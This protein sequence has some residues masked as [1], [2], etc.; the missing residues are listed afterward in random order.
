MT[1]PSDFLRYLNIRS[2]T[3]GSLRHD[4]CRLAFL[5]N[6][7]GTAQIWTVDGPSLWPEQRTFYSNRITFVSYSPV[8]N[9]LIFGMD[10]G[11]NEQDQF[12]LM[13]DEGLQVRPLTQLES[14]KHLWGGWSHSGRQIAFTGTRDHAAEFYPYTL[15]LESGEIRCIAQ[16]PGYNTVAAWLPDDQAVI[17]NRYGSNANSDLFY[18]ELATGQSRHLTPHE[19]DILYGSVRP[20]P[21]GSGLLLLSDAGRDFTNLAFYDFSRDSLEFLGEQAW[22]QEGLALTDDGR[23]LAVASNE[24]GYGVLEIHDRLQQSQTRIGGLPKGVLG[25]PSLG[26]D[27]Q[28]F[29]I[30]ATSPKTA[31]NVWAI[32]PETKQVTQWTASSLGT[33]P[34]QALVETE[35]VHYPSFDGLSIPAFYLKPAGV[36]GPLPVVIDIHGGPEGQSRPLFRAFSQYLVSQGYAVLLPN[37]RGSTGYGKAYSHLDDVYKRMDSVAD[38]KAAYDWLVQAGNAD[39][40]RIA[41]YGGSYGGFMVLSALTT[42]PE[43]WAAGVDV[44]GIASFV[45]FL[46][47]TSAYRRKLREAE[48]GDLERDRDFL[49]SI[50]PLTH[51][52]RITAP[53]MVIHGA[54]DPRVPVGEAE[55]IVAALKTR[56]VPVEYLC[57]VDEGHGLAKLEN[58]LDAYP[59]VVAFLDRYLK[60]NG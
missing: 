29:L 59:K 22:D 20:L 40:K 24:D 57:Y 11:G 35:L 18:L 60:P 25:S 30:T 13:D 3:G 23:W 15:D 2:S 44:V 41:V 7:T 51:V 9:Q 32:E 28:T 1:L 31:A 55:Q 17:I 5:N 52:E 42:Y 10:E 47:N 53:L 56:Q 50:S 38:L 34:P 33:V 14:A 27:G 6:T 49:H 39:P 8:S 45:T 54:N 58:R 16:L 46:E 21:D 4:G 48:Y 26:R 36:S 37:V 12:F 19:G 43:L